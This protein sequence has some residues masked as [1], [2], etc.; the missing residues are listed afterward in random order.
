MKLFY[1]DDVLLKGIEKYTL[2]G[3]RKRSLTERWESIIHSQ[4]TLS[5]LCR[6]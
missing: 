3:F 5:R 6:E 4:S 1:Q 2:K